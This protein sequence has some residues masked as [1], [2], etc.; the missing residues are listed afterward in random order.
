MA[1]EQGTTSSDL[2]FRKTTDSITDRGRG[3]G[4]GLALKD[5]SE[6]LELVILHPHEKPPWKNAHL[7]LKVDLTGMPT[8]IWGA[9]SNVFLCSQSG[10]TFF[11]LV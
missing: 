9:V 8:S 10:P 1:H 7:T 4:G 2:C 6:D 3:T 11:L 5:L